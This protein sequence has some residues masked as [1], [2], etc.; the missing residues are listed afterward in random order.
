MK[1]LDHFVK[2]AAA[3]E[4]HVLDDFAQDVSEDLS[5]MIYKQLQVEEKIEQPL[6]IKDGLGWVKV[7]IYRK[8]GFGDES[9]TYSSDPI[10]FNLYSGIDSNGFKFKRRWLWNKVG[11]KY[12][13]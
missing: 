1:E 7:L 5:D 2:L 6:Y 8:I 11:A 3:K 4:Y 13:I 9:R 12:P 10:H